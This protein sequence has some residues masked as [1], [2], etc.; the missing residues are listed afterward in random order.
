MNFGFYP[1]RGPLVID[2]DCVLCKDYTNFE[3]VYRDKKKQKHL[4]EKPSLV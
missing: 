4:P 2:S 3:T 1:W